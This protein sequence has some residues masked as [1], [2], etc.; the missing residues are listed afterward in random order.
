M[1]EGVTTGG[2]MFPEPGLDLH[3][4]ESTWASVEQD[5]DADP[6]A[7]VSQFADIVQRML[8]ERGYNI[9]D[10]VE[11]AGDEREVV[12]TYRSAREVA[13]R[14]ELGEASRGD[15]EG[16]I[17]DLRALFETIATERP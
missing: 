11:A 6:D 1:S 3:D 2:S 7:A 12:V 10:P 5:M 4:W 14:A 17:E 13:E 9:A 15:V 8:R 16:A